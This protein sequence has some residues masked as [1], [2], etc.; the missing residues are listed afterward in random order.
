MNYFLIDYE[1]IHCEGIRNL[2]EIQDSDTLIIFYSDQCKSISFEALEAILN[3]KITYR[4]FKA[5]VGTK[6][7]LDFQLSAY[8][9]YLIGK[10]SETDTKYFIVSNDKGYDCLYDFWKS[11]ST[12]VIRLTTQPENIEKKEISKAAAAS[13]KKKAN[14]ANK[15]KKSKTATLEEIKNVISDE[16]DPAEIL[17]IFNRYKTKVEIMNGLAK[18]FKDSKKAGSIYKKLKPLLREKNKT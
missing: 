5:S 11:F 15:V 6:N 8:L 16:E 2:K 1:N 13:T 10:N 17:E 7:A 4:C 3:K 9:G 12:N 14:K 18:K